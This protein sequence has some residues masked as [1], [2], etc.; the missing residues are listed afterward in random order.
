MRKEHWKIAVPLARVVGEGFFGISEKLL[1]SR[2]E[3]LHSFFSVA[4]EAEVSILLFNFRHNLERQEKLMLSEISHV[5]WGVQKRKEKKKS[6]GGNS[7]MYLK[8][9]NH[10]DICNNAYY[11]SFGA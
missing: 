1:P 3:P 9:K 7:V 11:T 6:C 10:T 4:V 8:K 2:P 5:G